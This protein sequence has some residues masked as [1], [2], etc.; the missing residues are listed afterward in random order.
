MTAAGQLWAGPVERRRPPLDREALTLLLGKVRTW[1]AFDGEAL[2]DDVA[3][4]LDDVIP[5]EE[6]VD[7]LTER[8]L[9][10][11]M[12]LVTIAVAAEEEQRDAATARLKDQARTLSC[13]KVPGGPLQGR[14]APA[15][16]RLDHQR[17]AGKPL[18]TKESM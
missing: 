13:E 4:V 8:L 10:H 14:G 17:A 11:L 5:A 16:N 15:P 7:E 12:R 3:A 1:Q 9:G 6:H 2:L 18:A